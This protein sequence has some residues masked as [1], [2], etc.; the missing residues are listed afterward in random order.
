LTALGRRQKVAVTSWPK[1]QGR[2][3]HDPDRRQSCRRSHA[4]R[5]PRTCSGAD[6]ES[7]GQGLRRRGLLVVVLLLV[8]AA[9]LGSLALRSCGS[10]VPVATLPIFRPGYFRTTDNQW[11]ALEFAT[12]RSAVF[13]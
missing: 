13:Q 10:A 8:M 7:K 4:D 5:R 11:K 2:D 1:R 6:P 12:V 3:F 9:L